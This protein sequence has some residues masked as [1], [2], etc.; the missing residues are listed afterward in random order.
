MI[1]TRIVPWRLNVGKFAKRIGRAVGDQLAVIN[2]GDVAAAL[3][4]VHVVRGDEKSDAVPGKFK[5]QDPKV[6]GARPDRC[7]PSVRREKAAS[8]H[9]AWRSPAP[10]AASIRRIVLRTGDPDKARAR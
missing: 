3:R 8:A 9:A 7:P 5:Q 10:A 4:F 2:V 1:S 6:G